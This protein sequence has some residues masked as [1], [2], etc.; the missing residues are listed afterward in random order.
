MHDINIVQYFNFEKL[1]NKYLKN[2]V[3]HAIFCNLY[4]YFIDI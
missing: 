4:V 2:S 3:F 1:M